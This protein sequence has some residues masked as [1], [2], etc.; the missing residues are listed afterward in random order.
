VT[1]AAS[2]TIAPDVIAGEVGRHRDALTTPALVLDLER[3]RVNA[4]RMG[5]RTRE[6]GVALRP[7]VKVHKS[8]RLARIQL[9]AGA[10]GVT[11]ATVW[12]AEAM[13]RGGIDDILVAN[14]VVG[15]RPQRLLARLA[16]HHRVMALVDEPANA[17]QLGAAARAAGATIGV[18]VDV[19]SGMARCG[20]RSPEQ[21]RAVAEVVTATEGLALRGVSGY[22]GHCMLEPD[23]EVRGRMVGAAMDRVIA[24][25]D[26]ILGAGLPCD[27][28][29]AGGTGTY[30]LTGAR[31]RVTEVQAGSYLLMD[32]FH[33]ELIDGFVVALTV[34]STVISRQGGQ[35]V[36]D[37]GQ[38][39]LGSMSPRLVGSAAE[40]LF[41]NEEHSGFPVRSDSPLQ[42]GDRVEL[43]PGYAP[44]A[45]NL[46]DVF[47]VVEQG[48]VTD[49]WPVE[50]RY[51]TATIG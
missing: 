28:V 34:A 16:R 45:V 5:R 30:R 39:A 7:H 51:G 22:E 11:T 15:E 36:L 42:V 41:V 12:E 10:V 33:G 23:A 4:E 31:D 13:A 27:I 38:K 46:F 8:P 19:D 3:V 24:G 35:I 14:E 47:H 37:A 6:L 48:V 21:A 29:S 50:A 26:A 9:D 32:V 25:A 17:A 1:V 2:P 18:L 43:V 20:V 49:L 40:P 44:T